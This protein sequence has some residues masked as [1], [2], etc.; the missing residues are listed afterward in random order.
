MTILSACPPGSMTHKRFWSW[1][2]LTV[3][4][5]AIAGCGGGAGT[6]GND[7]PIAAQCIPGDPSTAAECGTVLIGL[8]DADGEFLSYAVDVLSLTL[9]RADGAVV[10]TMPASTRIDFSEYIDMTELVAVATLPP[11]TYVSGTITLDYTNA[12]VFVDAL[13]DAK[14]AIVVDALGNPMTQTS[15]KIELPQ[16]D[17]L[18]ISKGNAS[19][20]SVDFDL[21]A[22]HDVNI[23]PTPALAT[24]EPFIVAEVN[25]VDTKDFRVRGLLTEVNEAEMWYSVRVLPFHRH[26]NDFG[27]M[28]VHVT[29]D[30]E[31]EVNEESY[32]GSACLRAL[33]AAGAGTLTV[34]HGT[35]NLGDRR[36][37]ADIVLAGSSVPGHDKDAARGT[38]IARAVNELTVRGGTVILTDALRPAFFR[39]DITVTVGPDTIVYKTFV[40]DRPLGI[41]DRLLDIGAISPGQVVTVRGTVTINDENGIH[42]D[43][44]QGAVLLHVTHLSGIV[45]TILPGQVD[46]DLHT[47]GRV[48]ASAVDFTCTGGCEPTTDADPDNYEVAVGNLFLAM[49]ADA[50]GR[51]V[52]AWGFPAEFGAAPPDFEGRTIVDYSD[53]KSVLGI[54]WGVEGTTA[55]FLMMDGSGLLLDNKNEHID[56]RHYIKQGPVLIDLT[57]LDSN[58][59]IAPRETGRMLFVVKTT[60]SLQQYADFDDF[61]RALTLELDGVNAARSMYA[62]GHYNA[63]TN[64]FTA[65]KIFVYILEP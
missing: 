59:L 38:V 34:A 41:A 27:R 14:Q 57:Q 47:I 44:T 28:R 43:A 50:T 2:A 62:R 51:P 3:A 60:D 15:L 37:T 42:I 63:D 54:G 20:L 8:T 39:R 52:A 29:D 64:V 49:A 53:V 4:V 58:T 48:R 35:L 1:L 32:K 7:D 12:E 45:N 46:I 31:C 25:P 19:L 65:Y 6:V 22:S 33:N 5:L 17:R 40:T 36:F 16:R 30:T 55:P 26:A 21:E 61:V 56:Q 23:I 10:E 18:F 9:E 11:G 24:A 13:G